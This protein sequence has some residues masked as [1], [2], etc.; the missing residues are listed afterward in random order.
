[1]TVLCKGCDEEK[2]VDEFGRDAK[3]KSGKRN[4]CKK[5]WAAYHR[6]RYKTDGHYRKRYGITMEDY[7][8]MVAHQDGLCA[9]CHQK[10]PFRQLFVDHDHRTNKVRG[11]LCS[12]CNTG[13]GY[14]KDDCERMK[15]AIAYVITNR[16]EVF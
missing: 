6:V 10:P 3:A 8:A 5:C 15:Q 16:V 2:S 9:I 13:I 7:Q 1:M 4:R 14:F 12:P 11:L